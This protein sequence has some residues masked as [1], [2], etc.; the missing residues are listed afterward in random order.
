M[1]LTQS[2]KTVFTYHCLACI[3][4][5]VFWGAMTILEVMARRTLLAGEFEVTLLAMSMPLSNILSIFWAGAMEGKATIKRYLF[6][7]GVCGRLVF[8]LAFWV[9]GPLSLISLVYFTV[10]FNGLINPAINGIFQANYRRE[11]RALLFG[12]AIVV[13]TPV[14]MLAS[15][16]AG[17]LLDMNEMLYAPI[18]AAAAVFGLL[19][20]MMYMFMPR[21]TL[22]PPRGT[23]IGSIRK[24]DPWS[25]ARGSLDK[26]RG[27][28]RADPAFAVFERNYFLSG[29]GHLLLFP[30]IP[31]YA[32]DI[33]NLTYSQYT[34]GRGIFGMVALMILPPIFGML[35]RHTNPFRF[36]TFSMGSFIPY[37]LLLLAASWTTGDASLALLYAGFFLIGVGASANFLMWQLGSLY[38]APPGQARMYQGIHVTF[39]GVRSLFMPLAGYGLM[40]L[41]GIQYAFYTATV[42]F[43]MSS[44]MMA[45]A[46]R[47]FR[48]IKA[49]S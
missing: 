40:K 26:V 24:R 43:A 2:E 41:V 47:E 23:I 29:S 20:C 37:P 14:V 38:F 48:G 49:R 6:L 9:S 39:T 11:M 1:K 4:G 22:Q 30:I 15:R 16:L 10:I 12:L 19:D 46:N 44:V 18:L 13:N 7:A 32:V 35:G 28:L 25:L 31:I 3:F 21:Q 34:T 8:V 45:R 33:L 36:C 5:G 42:F 17:H 27:I